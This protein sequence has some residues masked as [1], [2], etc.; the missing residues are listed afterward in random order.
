MSRARSIIRL[1]LLFALWSSAVSAWNPNNCGRD[2]VLYTDS[3]VLTMLASSHDSNAEFEP[4][5]FNEV[6]DVDACGHCGHASAHLLGL[7]ARTLATPTG[8]AI[9]IRRTTELTGAQ[10]PALPYRPPQVTSSLV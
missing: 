9:K 3:T 4:A 1:L 10:P 5:P 2:R 6:S 8:D 7:A